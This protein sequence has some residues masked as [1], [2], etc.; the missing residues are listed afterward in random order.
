MRSAHAEVLAHPDLVEPTKDFFPDAFAIDAHSVATLVQRMATYAPLSSDLDIEVAFV[1]PED[2]EDTGASAGCCGGSCSTTSTQKSKSHG[3]SCGQSHD[4][5]RELGATASARETESGYA[6]LLDVASVSD[7]VL[8]TS[9]IARALGRIVLFEAGEEVSERIEG[10]VSELTAVAC[11]LGVLLLN[12]SCVYKKACSGLREHHGTVLSTSELALA[13]ALFVRATGNKPS[14]VR[15][16]LPATQREAFDDALAWTNDQPKIVR[17]LA[18]HPET[19]KD[20]LF[21]LEEQKGF[22][23]RLFAGNS[24]RATGAPEEENFAIQPHQPKA[25]TEEQRRRL[26]ETKALVEEALKE[27]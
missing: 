10:A 7:S 17:A 8:L 12:G 19:L 4:Q 20:G 9:A 25:R 3:K 21:D 15:K 16:H 13:V 18:E 14:Q 22:F 6:V 11:G 27:P 24:N 23:A 5:S 1:E 26:A 2:A